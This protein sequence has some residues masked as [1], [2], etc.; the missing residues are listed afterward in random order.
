M[1]PNV[2]RKAFPSYVAAQTEAATPGLL[3]INARN[4]IRQSGFAMIG[5]L[6]AIKAVLACKGAVAIRAEQFE[7]RVV[8]FKAMACPVSEAFEGLV[9]VETRESGAALHL[10]CGGGIVL[11]WFDA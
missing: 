7:L 10:I 2:L 5:L 9:T 1:S 11:K 6:M 3:P 4:W 8:D